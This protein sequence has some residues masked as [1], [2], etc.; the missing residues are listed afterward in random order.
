[1]RMFYP[2]YY[3]K[4]SKEIYTAKAGDENEIAILP[5]KTDG[6][7]GRWRWKKENVENNKHLLV[8]KKNAKDKYDIYVK[9]FLIRDGVVKG[10]KTNTFLIDK[11]IINDKAKE[12]LK[13]L[14]G[15]KNIFSYPKSEYLLH[16]LIEI[17]SK[18]GDII[19]DFFLG[20]G[21]TAAVAHKMNRQYIG[22]EQMDYIETIS[23]ERLRKVIEGEQGGISKDVDWHGG[24]SFVYCELKNDAQNFV[25]SI[26]NATT[27][28]ELIELFNL[29]KQSSFLSYRIDPKK[30]KESEFK[31]L[32]LAEQ[33]QLLSEI[34]DSNNLYVNYAD[35]EDIDYAV[36]PQDKKL[37]H[38]FYGGK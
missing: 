28:E 36:S 5:I 1:P 30:L 6:S 35:I 18:A 9:D 23:V 24:G 15:E 34:I 22:I 13:C 11:N 12:H 32:S 38:E 7:E 26:K 10:S 2:I 25:E 31:L 29:A 17:T 21:T 33:K 3:N 20:S 37:N 19:L 27:T 14:F 8:C 16:R 4:V